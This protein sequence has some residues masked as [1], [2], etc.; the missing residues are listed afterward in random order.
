MKKKKV[1]VI[2]FEIGN[3]RL[4]IVES[5]GRISNYAVEDIP[6]DMVRNGE[7]VQWDA[8]AD[9]IKSCMKKNHFS[10]KKAAIAVPDTVA[11]LRRSSMP[12]MSVS[13][14]DYNLPYEF[15]DFITDDKDK[16]VYDYSM[17][18]LIKDEDGAVTEMDMLSVAAP[19]EIMVR[20][21]QMFKRA[22]LK[23]ILAAPECW[24]MENIFHYLT[25]DDGQNDYA[26]LDLGWLSSRIYIFSHGIYE[27]T[28][29]IDT[30]CQ[31]VTNHIADA[32][33]CDVHIAEIMLR[34]NRNGLLDS[35]ECRNIYSRIAIDV[36]RAI[37]YYTFEN[38]DNN[39][40]K[41]YYCGG[42]SVIEPLIQE[43]RDTIQLELV[44]LSDIAG[45]NEKLKSAIML[46]PAATG[47][48]WG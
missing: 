37:N 43:I 38:R 16:Y 33:A 41:L 48:C 45:D 6:E 12:A 40:E 39:L 31:T 29:R 17:I 24:A 22:G 19:K 2:G 30:A 9:F 11:Y 14:L 13:Q 26:V 34:E 28:R 47:I 20:Y 44:P 46:G 3:S 10:V 27:V 1:S 42:G 25:E 18:D 4:K 21:M 32:N 15:H 35:E 5:K 36:M 8:M 7:V 23:L